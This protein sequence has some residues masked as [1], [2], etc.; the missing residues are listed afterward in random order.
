[1]AF[2]LLS[3]GATPPDRPHIICVGSGFA[4]HGRYPEC[5]VGEF[6]VD[7]PII[8]AAIDG[9]GLCGIDRLIAIDTLRNATSAIVFRRIFKEKCPACRGNHSE[10][11][12]QALRAVRHIVHPGAIDKL[13]EAGVP[14][15]AM[16]RRRIVSD[17]QPPPASPQE[18]RRL[19]RMKRFIPVYEGDHAR[20]RV[21]QIAFAVQYDAKRR[22]KRYQ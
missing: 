10:F 15:D 4:W 11:A 22:G 19:A 2:S 6:A 21:A 7:A 1:M 9:E 12:E 16:L 18:A 5:Y 3:D 14:M 13:R 17:N 8:S 20:T